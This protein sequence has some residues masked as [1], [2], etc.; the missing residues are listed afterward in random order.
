MDYLSLAS[1][2]LR[3]ISA[4]S[5]EQKRSGQ[6]KAQA[7]GS[8]FILSFI[9]MAKKPIRPGELSEMSGFSTAN[10][11]MSLKTLENKGYITREIDKTDRRRTF[12]SATELGLEVHNKRAAEYMNGIV[13][14]FQDLGEKDSLDYIRILNRMLENSRRRNSGAEQTEQ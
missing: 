14:L 6:P 12:V 3:I 11:A 7:E 2:Y 4:L 5:A 9:A 13:R 10:I 1:E 8:L